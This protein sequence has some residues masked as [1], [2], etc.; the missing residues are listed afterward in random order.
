MFQLFRKILWD[1]C[2]KNWINSASHALVVAG[3]LSPGFAEAPGV[4]PVHRRLIRGRQLLRVSCINMNSSHARQVSAF[5]LVEML[6]VMAII[7]IL[8]ALLLPGVSRVKT[9][10][11][12]ISCLNN[13]KQLGLGSQM[14]SDDNRG[15]FSG[16]TWWGPVPGRD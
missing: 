12:R 11:R 14:Y 9:K 7:S 4:Q 8:A 10:A 6:V 13:L 2:E 1:G 5:I 16:S 3:L 15:H